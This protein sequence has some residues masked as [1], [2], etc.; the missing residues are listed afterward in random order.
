MRLRNT[1]GFTLVELLVVI[2]IIGLLASVVV[3]SVG[4]AREKARDAT[5]LSDMDSIR[6]AVELYRDGNDGLAP[7]QGQE[8]TDLAPYLDPFPT[9]P[10]SGVYT[11]YNTGDD[12]TFA[13]EFTTEQD[14]NIGT[15]GTYCATSAGIQAL[16]GTDCSSQER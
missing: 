7:A 4:A 12:D 15:A 2:A 6:T 10:S 1:K 3:V 8:E 13:V 5:R 14:S 16:S 9:D 11:Y